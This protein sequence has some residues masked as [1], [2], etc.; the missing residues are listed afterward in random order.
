MNNICQR[1][2]FKS[3]GFLFSL[4][5]LSGS[6]NVEPCTEMTTN[7][8]PF[9]IETLFRIFEHLN[10]DKLLQNF[11]VLQ[12]KNEKFVK[13]PSRTMAVAFVSFSLH[14]YVLILSF[15]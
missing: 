1:F 2:R 13:S 4:S 6:T 12:L 15:D 10:E 8:Q 14:K 11:Q 7:G 9:Q 3:L 5:S